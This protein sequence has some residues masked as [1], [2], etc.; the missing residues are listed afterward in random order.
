MKDINGN[1]I[2]LQRLPKFSLSINREY[3]LI[4]IT[5]NQ[6]LCRI[7]IV[8]KRDEI[9]LVISAMRWDGSRST[10]SRST[11]PRHALYKPYEGSGSKLTFF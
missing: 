8:S 7:G 3:C 11:I 10:V 6:I 5:I 9:T 4:K 1:I 2:H